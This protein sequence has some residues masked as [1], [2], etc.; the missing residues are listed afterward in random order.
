MKR[1]EVSNSPYKLFTKDIKDERL[2]AVVS[3]YPTGSLQYRSLHIFSFVLFFLFKRNK[4]NTRKSVHYMT[5]KE[6]SVN[7][8]AAANGEEK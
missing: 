4:K 3:L 1:S 5:G 7:K 6:E 2:F 8:C